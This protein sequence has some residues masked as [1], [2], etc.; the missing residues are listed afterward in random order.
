MVWYTN[1]DCTGGDIYQAA[2][3]MHHLC[4]QMGSVQLGQEMPGKE[5]QSN[6]AI[7][8]VSLCDMVSKLL[9]EICLLQCTLKNKYCYHLVSL[10]ISNGVESY[11]C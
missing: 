2:A 1:K 3:K 4:S 7:K 6:H 9:K 11:V 10:F 8:N 5:K